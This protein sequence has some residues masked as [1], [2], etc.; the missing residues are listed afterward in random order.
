M[1]VEESIMGKEVICKYL[2]LVIIA[3]FVG[4][5]VIPVLSGTIEKASYIYGKNS[6]S[7]L[8]WCYDPPIA[9]FN[10]YP[11]QPEVGQTVTFDASCSQGNITSYSWFYSCGYYFPIPLGY[12][13]IISTSF[14]EPCFAGTYLIGLTVD[15]PGGS[16]SIDHYVMVVPKQNHQ[17]NTP[18]QPSGPTN[19]TI[20][21][22]FTY[23]TS[24]T[25]S[26][27]DKIKYG[28]DWNGDGNVD[29]WS[30]LQNSGLTCSMSHSWGSSGTYQAKV[31]AQDEHGAESSWS[32]TLIVT[33]SAANNPP[34]KP[35]TPTG[36]NSGKTGNSYSYSSLAIDPDGDQVYLM[37]DW[38]DGNNSGWKGPYSSGQNVTASH[39]WPADGSYTVT[40]KAKD[41]KGDE[42]V[43]SDPLPITMPYSYNNPT[44]RFLELLSQRFRNVF[45]I[46][47]QLMGY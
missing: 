29:N 15:G 39:I 16:N 37:F 45:S 10:W 24:T 30:A 32:S 14:A 33:I 12:G 31:K 47:R 38:S 44:L 42:S 17:P 36:P 2:V 9:C 18:S 21:T 43:W 23:T 6:V 1:V 27:G 13:K 22:V 40:V 7:E 20:G 34:N 26:D 11:Y 5:G 28:W 8:T 46:L 35:I 4:V 19:G 25:D 3:L 41:T